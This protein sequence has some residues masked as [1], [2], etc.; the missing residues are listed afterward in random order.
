MAQLLLAATSS[1]STSNSSTPE[2]P[3]PALR[4]LTT[5]LLLFATTFTRRFVDVS[6]PLGRTQRP[7]ELQSVTVAGREIP[8]SVLYLPPCSPAE[9]AAAGNPA[10]S[11]ANASGLSTSAPASC[12]LVHVYFPGN[13][14]LCEFYIETMEAVR[15]AKHGAT[16]VYCIGHA[17]QGFQ[18]SQAAFEAA[19]ADPAVAAD[20]AGMRF[21]GDALPKTIYANAVVKNTNSATNAAAASENTLNGCAHG[22]FMSYPF[23][24]SRPLSLRAQIAHKLAVLTALRRRHPRATFVL[25]GHSMGSHCIMET[26]RSVERAAA[27]RRGG[28]A[29]LARWDAAAREGCESVSDS[30]AVVVMP[31]PGQRGRRGGD[32]AAAGLGAE[33]P[34]QCGDV[35]AL[36]NHVTRVEFSAEELSEWTDL[37]GM[38][39]TEK[40]ET[41]SSSSVN[42]ISKDDHA[43]AGNPE[44]ESVA[45]AADSEPD[46]DAETETHAQTGKDAET[47]GDCDVT[48]TT[49]NKSGRKSFPPVVVGA[50]ITTTSRSNPGSAGSP[51]KLN[52]N[53]TNAASAIKLPVAKTAASGSARN[54]EFGSDPL[55]WVQHAQLLFPT[56]LRIADS[57]NGDFFVPLFQRQWIVDAV[58]TAIGWL[59]AFV[60][61]TLVAVNVNPFAAPV[62]HAA[63]RMVREWAVLLLFFSI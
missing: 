55:A 35:A 36:D 45:T 51:L 48:K 16:H 9:A 1:T 63:A 4:R 3:F 53:T 38:R 40:C 41:K 62:V 6:N 39:W 8:T 46:A 61:R 33:R 34:R 56:V 11:S 15:R 42:V 27:L 25:S 19:R 23:D 54:G 7:A 44:S 12:E 18:V 5:F 17:G 13:P 26:L 47:D 57:P 20:V 29:G 28:A 24:A 58:L 59:P 32:P 30:E 21:D 50:T 2:R 49:N 52:N 37:D 10:A 31:R 22:R 43:C 60:R 14:G